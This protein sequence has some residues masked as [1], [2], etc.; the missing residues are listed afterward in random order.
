MR[1]SIDGLQCHL[2]GAHVTHVSIPLCS[3]GKSCPTIILHGPKLSLDVLQ[4]V[5]YATLAA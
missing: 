4:A 3:L 2:E 1:G 5:L